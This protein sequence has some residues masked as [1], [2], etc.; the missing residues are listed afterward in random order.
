MINKQIKQ[1]TLEK[2][3]ILVIK[4]HFGGKSDN[5]DKLL[6][7]IYH[8]NINQTT[9]LSVKTNYLRKLFNKFQVKSYEHQI[10]DIERLIERNDSPIFK[11]DK[12]KSYFEIVYD[13]YQSSLATL[14]VREKVGNDY[15][16]LI[17]LSLTEEERKQVED[18]LEVKKD[19]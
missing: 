14:Q 19:E 13:Y 5:L 18:L 8:Y 16:D 10:I 7:Y 11:S 15:K 12:I 17:D 2:A 6:N 9:L 3:I 4:N 1:E